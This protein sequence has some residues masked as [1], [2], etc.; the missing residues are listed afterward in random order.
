MKLDFAVKFEIGTSQPGRRTDKRY[1][2]T[3][4]IS[5][6]VTLFHEINSMQS[7]YS[8]A[9]I[10]KSEKNH[11]YETLRNM[12]FSDINHNIYIRLP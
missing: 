7:G 4:S 12:L 10:S 9:H 2:K 8:A 11:L 1:A 3:F 6:S 5:F